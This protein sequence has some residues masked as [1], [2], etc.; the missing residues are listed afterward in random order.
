MKKYCLTEILA[1]A[2]ISIAATA[3]LIIFCVSLKLSVGVYAKVFL[4]FMALFTAFGLVRFG[5]ELAKVIW[6]KK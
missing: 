5:A 4:G 1:C 3:M 2:L 6:G